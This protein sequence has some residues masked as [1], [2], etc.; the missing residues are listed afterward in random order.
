MTVCEQSEKE[1]DAKTMYEQSE[2]DG[3]AMTV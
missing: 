2:E 1:G 3:G